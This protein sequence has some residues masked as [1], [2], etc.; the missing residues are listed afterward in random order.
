M[1]EAAKTVPAGSRETGQSF[2]ASRSS[3][4]GYPS[5][6]QLLLQKLAEHRSV[7]ERR[8]LKESIKVIAQISWKDFL[9]L[10]KFPAFLGWQE[11]QA[12]RCAYT[13]FG[14]RTNAACTG[15][16]GLKLP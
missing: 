14:N 2:G 7:G 12:R 8:H 11:M 5:A 9:A 4:S 6:A 3:A 16:F 10:F 15:I 1:A 13:A